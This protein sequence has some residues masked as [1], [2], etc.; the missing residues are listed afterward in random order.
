MGVQRKCCPFPY[1]HPFLFS[2]VAPSHLLK[3]KNGEERA[4][5]REQLN[6]TRKSLSKLT[7]A[8]RPLPWKDHLLTAV[9]HGQVQATN[10]KYKQCHKPTLGTSE[11]A[12]CVTFS[13]I[14]KLRLMSNR[15]KWVACHFSTPSASLYALK[16]LL[17]TT[18]INPQ[19]IRAS[20]VSCG[21][22]GALSWTVWREAGKNMMQPIWP[23]ERLQCSFHFV[24]SFPAVLACCQSAFC[25][26]ITFGGW[27]KGYYPGRAN[28]IREEKS[29]KAFLRP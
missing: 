27:G 10:N 25:V 13:P 22:C 15:F 24:V 3:G 19:T 5:R 23:L 26:Y 17:L 8:G 2:F 21:E 14:S 20:P 28:N 29:R 4:I 1:T 6:Y 7:W 18:T 11:Y 9:F 16:S 12:C